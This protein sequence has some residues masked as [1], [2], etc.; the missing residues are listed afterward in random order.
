MRKGVV[1]AGF[2]MPKRSFLLLKFVS[3]HSFQINEVT[4]PF[5]SKCRWRNK[6]VKI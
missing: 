5:Q 1:V 6:R 3:T 2:G 4:F